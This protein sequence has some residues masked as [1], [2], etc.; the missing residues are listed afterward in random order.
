MENNGFFHGKHLRNLPEIL[1]LRKTFG[2]DGYATYCMLLEM[3]GETLDGEASL[4][5]EDYNKEVIAS[6]IGITHEKLDSII[7]Y[8]CRIKKAELQNGILLI[9]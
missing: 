4:D 9:Y 1:A 7:T 2:L 6:D 3:S 5:F 8:L